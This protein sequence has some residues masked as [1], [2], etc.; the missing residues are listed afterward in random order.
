MW[1]GFVVIVAILSTLR[2][3]YLPHLYSMSKVYMKQRTQHLYFPLDL[4]KGLSTIWIPIVACNQFSAAHLRTGPNWGLHPTHLHWKI[5]KI[6]RNITGNPL[7]KYRKSSERE[8]DKYSRRESN[9]HT[10]VC[11]CVYMYISSYKT[12][13][14]NMKSAACISL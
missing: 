10:Y 2:T 12:A 1:Y 4:G 8:P 7:E 11:T 13:F 14:A 6:L 9:E 5:A 3:I